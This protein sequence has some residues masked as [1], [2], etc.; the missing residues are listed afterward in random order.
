MSRRLQNY[1]LASA[2]K[3]REVVRAGPFTVTI[4]GH[5]PNVY[6]N[7]AVP[8][9]DAD[10]TAAD[11][12]ALIAAFTSR[13]RTPRLE[14][15]P[16]LAPR[17]EPAL[18]DA[19]FTVAD[20]LPIMECRPETLID[21]A[22]PPGFELIT[23]V[24]DEDTE[25]MLAAQHEAFGEAPPTP[26]HVASTRAKAAAGHIHLLAREAATGTAA[27]G[28]VAVAVRDGI[29]EVAGIAVRPQYERRGLGAS[30]TRHLTRS[31]FD[32]GATLT[33]L[34]PA[35]D[36]QERVYARVGYRR[37]DSVLFLSYSA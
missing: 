28:G 5:D 20:R 15:L 21:R 11:V 17:V 23:P 7:Y 10:P 36:A 3:G 12:E 37:G 8:D 14:Y 18:V 30:L 31:A 25:A 6:V 2:K 29:S 32:A 26:Q 4:T 33:F 13:G 35:G 27:G 22:D 24:T 16:S 19:G 9:A 1:M 34:T